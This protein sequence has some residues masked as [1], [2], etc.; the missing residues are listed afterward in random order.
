MKKEKVTCIMLALMAVLITGI[1]FILMI[2]NPI[3]SYPNYVFDDSLLNNMAQNILLGEWLGSYDRYILIKGVSFPLYLAFNYML[4]IPFMMGIFI[5]YFVSSLVMVLAIRPWIKSKWLLIVIYTFFLYSPIGFMTYSVQRVYRM[6]VVVPTVVMIIA[7]SIAIFTY[8][9]KSI[10]ILAGWYVLLGVSLAFYWLLREEAILVLP[11]VI[12]SIILCVLFTCLSDQSRTEKRK[13]YVLNIIPFIITILY[14]GSISYINYCNYGGFVL[15]DR[16]DTNFEKVVNYLSSIETNEDIDENVW[17]TREAIKMAVANSSKLKEYEMEVLAE[18]DKWSVIRQREDGEV[19]GDD[20]VWAIRD[21]FASAGYY[22]D[23][24]TTDQIYEII[25]EDLRNAFKTGELTK[26]KG[27]KIS[28][29]VKPLQGKDILQYLKETLKNIPFIA[30]YTGCDAYIPYVEENN[31]E[32][33][34]IEELTLS[35]MLYEPIISSVKV[36]GW[37]FAVNENQKLRIALTDESGKLIEELAFMDSPDVQDVFNEIKNAKKSRIEFENKNLDSKELYMYIYIDDQLV[38]DY[39]LADVGEDGIYYD[40]N[41][42]KM[43]LNQVALEK[44][45]SSVKNE[46]VKNVEIENLIIRG[47]SKTGY[48]LLIASIIS[49][50]IILVRVIR[51]KEI[52]L[53]EC[54]LCLTG[55][56]LSIVLQIFGVIVFTWNGIYLYYLQGAIPMLQIFE[57]LAIVMTLQII[58]K[59][60]VWRYI[61]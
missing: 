35:K 34:R 45:N 56:L 47:Y 42:Y 3:W 36:S 18:W 20:Y 24:N 51:K 30:L 12:G 26:K 4:H 2:K 25:S 11:L 9:R 59:N 38:N 46:I 33:T 23:F 16:T 31:E 60:V 22:N 8:K 50:L 41:D 14:V 5:L 32:L 44:K 55:I 10:C 40:G 19:L 58:L 6:A 21:A 37:G 43:Y 1:R 48:S 57:A 7:C 28:F 49:Y 27:L 13:R 29:C 39:N 61:K 53:L 15:S 17:V 52:E 54:F